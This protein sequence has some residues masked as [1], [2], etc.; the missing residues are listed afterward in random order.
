MPR[1][2]EFDFGVSTVMGLFHQDW[3]YDGD[4]AADV[5]AKQLSALV[6]DEE[7]LAIRRDARTLGNLP[8]P[9]LEVLWEAGSQYFPAFDRVGGG[10][11][12]TRTVVALCDAR[13]SESSDVPP[14]AGADVED[15][16]ECLDAIVAEIEGAQ[17]LPAKV[18][19]AL[20]D[21]ATHCTPEV[22]FRVLLGAINCAPDASLSSEQYT[23][24][25]AIGADLQY[26]EF[27]VDSVR[28]LI[29]QQ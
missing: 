12:W 3:I 7:V 17:F 29:E 28:Y 6:D 19:V 15:G 9:T 16:V 22:A 5:V 21:C 24:L 20:T 2:T 13:L 18:R 25:E 1:F 23:R 8:S 4:T 11:E 27:A 26:G 10:A 14:L